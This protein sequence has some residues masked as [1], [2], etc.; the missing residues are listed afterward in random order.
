MRRMSGSML[1]LVN[2][3]RANAPQREAMFASWRAA[4]APQPA[5]TT[6]AQP[7]PAAAPAAAPAA[8]AAPANPP[9]ADPSRVM[10][11]QSMHS[12]VSPGMLPSLR[13]LRSRL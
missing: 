8:P 9:A 4:H 6:A 1:N 7:V 3:Y 11:A 2:Q 12:M 10:R 5:Q 13:N